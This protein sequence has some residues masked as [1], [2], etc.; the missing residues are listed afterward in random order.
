MN[1]TVAKRA[2]I[3]SLILGALIGVASILPFIIG[4]CLFALMFLS[5][6]I[7]IIYMKKNEKH[8]GLPNLLI[9]NKI[10]LKIF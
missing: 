2:L 6:P 1:E 7:I 9:I 8:I 5:A 4:Y 10:K 3:F